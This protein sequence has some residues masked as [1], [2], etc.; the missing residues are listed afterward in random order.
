MENSAIEQWEACNILFVRK[1]VVRWKIIMWSYFWTL[2]RV[3]NEDWT[4]SAH[5]WQ[6][7][8]I[9]G[10]IWYRITRG[11]LQRYREQWLMYEF[12]LRSGLNLGP[13]RAHMASGPSLRR[14]SVDHNIWKFWIW[15]A[16]VFI[17]N[18]SKK[19][20]IKSVS[21]VIVLIKF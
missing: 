2:S 5:I 15:S 13:I 6:Q 10:L 14:A 16:M 1:G 9:F 19:K 8:T 20:Y 7:S 21:Y 17:P 12:H 11:F 18:Y 4:V 3:E